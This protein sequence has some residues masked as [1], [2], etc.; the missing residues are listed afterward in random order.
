[1]AINTTPKETQ[2]GLLPRFLAKVKFLANPNLWSQY[3]K[4]PLNLR[5]EKDLLPEGRK[6]KIIVF[7]THVIAPSTSLFNPVEVTAHKIMNGKSCHSKTSSL[8]V[9]ILDRSG[10]SAVT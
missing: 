9:D 6:N 8:V 1:M 4:Q 10:L 2:G 7:F 5:V 3:C